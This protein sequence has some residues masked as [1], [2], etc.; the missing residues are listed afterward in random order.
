[1]LSHP[2]SVYNINS[3]SNEAGHISKIFDLILCYKLHLEQSLFI[4]SSLDKQDLIFSFTWL[5]KHNSKIDWQKDKIV[6]VHC[7]L[8]YTG[9]QEIYRAN[10]Y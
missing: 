5:K 2:V 7:L 3:T 8:Y 6:T 4:V 1:M 9:C 10:K